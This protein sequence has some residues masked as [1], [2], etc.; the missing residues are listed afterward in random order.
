MGT[1]HFPSNDNG[2]NFLSQNDYTN[3]IALCLRKETPHRAGRAL[4]FC[5]GGEDRAHED[6]ERIVRLRLDKLDYW[7]IVDRELLFERSV[8]GRY[9]F[10]R[11]AFQQTPWAT[12][13]S[14]TLT[15]PAMFAPIT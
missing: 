7:R 9:V 12:I 13:A 10:Y 3:Y 6:A 15:K 14:A 11:H 8:H 1:L 2:G 5:P 4:V